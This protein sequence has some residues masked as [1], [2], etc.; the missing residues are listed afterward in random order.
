MRD[1][2]DDLRERLALL[3]Q[4][5]DDLQAQLKEKLAQIDTYEQQLT[6]LLAMEEARAAPATVTQTKAADSSSEEPEESAEAIN[7]R[8]E[9]NILEILGDGKERGHGDIKGA[10]EANGW[11]AEKKGALGRQIHGVLLTLKN[12]GAV[13]YL[14][15]SVWRKA[16]VKAATAA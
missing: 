14:G 3:H 6:T 8:F 15:G 7:A 4:Q 13:D 16:K 1:I 2:R 5:R 12:R 10:M 9:A 11:Y